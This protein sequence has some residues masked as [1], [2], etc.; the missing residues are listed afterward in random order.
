MN[1]FGAIEAGGTKFVCAIGNSDGKIL[2]KEIFP[3]TT[4]KNTI[5][6]IFDFFKKEHK[7]TPLTAIGIACFGPLNLHI[8]SPSYGEITTTPKTS[9]QHFNIVKAFKNEF[10]L[11]IGFDTD[12]NGAALGEYRF[13]AAKGI[14]TF[15][16][17]TVGTGIGV[18]G[19]AKKDLLHGL[20]HPEMGHIIIPQRKDDDFI[21][22]C[23]FHKNCLESLASGPSM[24]KRWGVK[25][26]L[27]LPDD[28]KA[29]DL[30]A[31]YL[32][33][34]I[35]NFIL[36][37]SPKKIIM[38]G[39]VMKQKS[40]FKKIRKNVQEQLNGYVKHEMIQDKIDEYIV[41][42]GLKDNVGILGAIALAE[43]ALEDS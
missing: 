25:A 9:W 3:T 36:C 15:I 34:G 12:V 5:P 17:I 20:I 31:Y 27:S 43:L 8:E 33:V 6:L 39:G 32:G 10:S 1:Y 37:I 30:E 19:M 4:P 23:P 14:D 7:K 16:Y 24:M 18:G 35:A 29:W 26:A 21:G 2:K 38:G 28:H 41:P 11:P 42:P 22:V 13:G 40:L